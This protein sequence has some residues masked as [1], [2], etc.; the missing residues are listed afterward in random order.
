MYLYGDILYLCECKQ[1]RGSRSV[2]GVFSVWV[3]M[4]ACKDVQ[5]QYYFVGRMWALIS[6]NVVTVV[7]GICRPGPRPFAQAVTQVNTDS[8][9]NFCFNGVVKENQTCGSTKGTCHLFT[10]FNSILKRTKKMQT[11][12]C[13]KKIKTLFKNKT[14]CGRI[15]IFEGVLLIMPSVWMCVASTAHQRRRFLLWKLLV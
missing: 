1:Q 3:M 2:H 7:C 8:R 5:V 4:L 9:K 15:C 14:F 12:L 10:T 11:W 6:V 13:N